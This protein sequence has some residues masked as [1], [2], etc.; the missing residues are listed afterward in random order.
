LEEADEA[1]EPEEFPCLSAVR[2]AEILLHT[3]DFWT[4]LRNK[5]IS[6]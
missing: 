6:F 1:E 5:K 4:T 2:R 3:R